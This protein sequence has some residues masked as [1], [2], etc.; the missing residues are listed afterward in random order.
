MLGSALDRAV[1]PIAA[2][3]RDARKAAT[4]G[5]PEPVLGSP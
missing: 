3:L 1:T 2:A 5:E 4:T